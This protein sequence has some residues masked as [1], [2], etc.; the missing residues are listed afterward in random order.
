MKGESQQPMHGELYWWRDEA[1]ATYFEALEG[2]RKSTGKHSHISDP[3]STPKFL[4]V[5][6]LRFTTMINLVLHFNDA[7]STA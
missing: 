5:C 3:V 4:S 6:V 1:L 2:L 7:I